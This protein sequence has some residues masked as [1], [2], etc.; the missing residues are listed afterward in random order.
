[1]LDPII[2]AQAWFH[3]PCCSSDLYDMLESFSVIVKTLDL[4]SKPPMRNNS[5][6][7]NTEQCLSKLSRSVGPFETN[8]GWR[9]TSSVVFVEFPDGPTLPPK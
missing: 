4:V 9:V 5:S 3:L 1:M 7:I 8:G 2:L 6:S